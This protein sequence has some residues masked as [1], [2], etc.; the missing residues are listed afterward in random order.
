MTT[1]PEPGLDLRLPA[2]ALVAWAA[3]LLGLL[4][5]AEVLAGTGVLAATAVLL[6][7]VRAGRGTGSGIAVVTA[8]GWGLTG[9]GVVAV[10]LLRVEAVRSGPVAELADAG[11]VVRVELVTTGD[12]RVREGPFGEVVVVRARA[13]V[14]TG[15]GVTHTVRVPV[16]VLGDLAWERVALGTRAR[17]TV[18]LSPP[19]QADLAA[20]LLPRGPPTSVADPSPW[21][22]GAAAVRA[23]M[24]DAVADQPE[25]PRTLVPAL[26]S[27]DDDGMPPEITEAFRTTGLTHLLAVSGTNLTLVVGA[28]LLL[29]RWCGVRSRGLLVVGLLGIAGFVLLARTEPSVVRAATMG[30]VALLAMGR[31]GRRHATRTLAAAVVLLLLWDP[32]WSVA[33]GFQLSVLATAGILWLAPGWRDR[34]M[35]WMPRPAAEAVS[36]PLA[37]QV[38]CTPVVAAL[39]SQ[40]SLV[41]VAAN[42]LAAPAVA[43]AT[44][45]GLAGGLTSLVWPWLGA[46]VATP[47][48]WCARWVIAVA[49]WGAAL[50]TAAVAWPVSAP[51]LV[52]LTVLTVLVALLLGPVLARRDAALLLTAVLVVCLLVPMPGGGGGPRWW[53]PW[54]S[55]WPPAG[56]AMVACDVGQGDGL[57]LR[58]GP[59]EAVVVDAGPDPDAMDGCLRR[60][61]VDRVPV[62]VLTHFHADHVAGLEGVLRGREVGAVETTSL[63]DPATGVRLVDEAAAA[64]GVPVRTASYGE[65]RRVGDL[66]WQVVGPIGRESEANDASVVVLAEV[67][68]E[69]GTRMLLLGD[70]EQPSQQRLL[71]SLPDLGG[72]PIDVLKVAHHGSA[73]QHP[74]LVRA[75]AA[76]LAVISVGADND[77]GHPSPFLLDLLGEIGAE[78]ARTDQLGDVA[79]V[80]RDG[81]VVVV[82]HNAPVR[83]P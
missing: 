49:E 35:R 29:A 46:L 8:V 58:V 71:R 13:E 3:A 53:P 33:A 12:A 65:S 67:A 9:V 68:G 15:R 51:G 14:V 38:A 69:P 37:A 22:D 44:V 78:V 75:A 39:S 52:G 77:Y 1:L 2:L 4:A 61:G 34:M 30:A 7:V 80:A 66:R 16:L 25:G 62:V 27:G 79:V 70:Q 36:I 6:V 74:E 57:V 40:V 26:V 48:A 73:D 47:G 55:A 23:G 10:A 11:A 20:V 59:G 64:A 60:L 28:L 19:R 83:N 21:W 56:W 18:R 17:A 32:W 24:H 43:P 82:G 41:A 31:N 81:E 63:R 5:P 54:P 45:L 50:P 42:I 72:A 76:D